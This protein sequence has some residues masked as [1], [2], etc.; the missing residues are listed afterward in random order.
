MERFIVCTVSNK[1]TSTIDLKSSM[2][3]FIVDLLR[4]FPIWSGS[5][6]IQYGEIY[7]FSR[8]GG[9][10]QKFEF[11]I[12]YGEIYSCTELP[13]SVNFLIFKIQYGEIY[14]YRLKIAI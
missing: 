7:S 11:K 6:K 9:A 8:R 4:F 12:Q 13:Y 10:F 5:F 3:R 2:E 1:S 14:R